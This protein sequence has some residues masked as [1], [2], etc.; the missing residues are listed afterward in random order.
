[1]N[2]LEI[3]AKTSMQRF[4]LEDARIH[5]RGF[6][7]RLRCI[8]SSEKE[9]FIDHNLFQRSSTSTHL[10]LFKYKPIKLKANQC[11]RGIKKLRFKL[12]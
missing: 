6:V 12:N 2:H 1:M 8:K 10:V 5:I 9:L 3:L 4:A 11:K 7:K